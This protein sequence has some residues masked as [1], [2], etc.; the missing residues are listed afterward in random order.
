[1]FKLSMGTR[2]IARTPLIL[3]GTMHDKS[4]LDGE[5]RTDLLDPILSD[6]D[7][8]KN[9]VRMIREFTFDDVDALAEVHPKL[10][11]PTLLVWGEEDPFFPVADAR[12]MADQFGG[13]TE[14][15]SIPQGKLLV[16]EEHPR[17]FAELTRTFVTEHCEMTSTV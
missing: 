3:G 7:A 17:R 10:T 11:M 2:F 1:M 15:V 8:M 5:F 14:F 9:V 16:H 6:D 13:R 4:L 12:A